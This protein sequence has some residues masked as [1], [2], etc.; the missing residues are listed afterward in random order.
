M[1]RVQT[2]RAPRL[3]GRL[4]QEMAR[5]QEMLAIGGYADLEEQRASV[6]EDE[7]LPH[8]ILMLDRWEGFIG[9]LSEVDNGAPLDQVMTFL[10]EG[11]SVG[12]HLVMTGDRQLASSRL[13]SLVEDKIGL[14]M[15]DRA[16]WSLIGLQP[17][18]M[19]EEVPEGRGFRSESGIEVQVALRAERN[20]R[21]GK[22]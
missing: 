22:T 2:D 19:P 16:D 14:R 18:K 4:T 17:R 13:G 6:P 7:R 1:Q 20:L 11:A 5:R 10:R 12:I 3:L 8:V 21:N 15:P 9:G